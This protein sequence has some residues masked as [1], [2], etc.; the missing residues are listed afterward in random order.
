MKSW[1]LLRKLSAFVILGEIYETDDVTEDTEG[2]IGRNPTTK[3]DQHCT[4]GPFCRF[5]SRHIIALPSRGS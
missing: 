4:Q 2:G 5:L 1:P 3:V